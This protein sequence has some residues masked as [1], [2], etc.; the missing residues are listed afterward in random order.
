MK[1]K[2]QRL[3][4]SFNCPECLCR[5]VWTIGFV[6]F[7]TV[8]AVAQLTSGAYYRIT[9]VQYPELV[10]SEDIASQKI[11]CAQCPEASKKY[12]GQL[13]QVVSS[14][15]SYQ[16]RNALTQRY[17]RLDKS[18]WSVQFT[19][20]TSA[21]TATIS[22]VSGAT[23]TYKIKYNSYYFMHCDAAANVV[24]WTEDASASQWKFEK[25]TI[26]STDLANAQSAYTEITGMTTTQKSN[27]LTKMKKY[28]NG[29]ACGSL[30]GDYTSASALKTAMSNDGIPEAISLRA[31]EM[32]ETGADA[33]WRNR[34]R[35]HSYKAYSNPT[36]WR[37]KLG[38]SCLT[39]M[40]NPTGI[41][42]NDGEV[43]YVVVGGDIPTNAT[44]RLAS[45]KGNGILSSTDGVTLTKGLNA[46]Y[47]SGDSI[48]WY[49]QYLAETLTSNG[50]MRNL[51]AFNPIEIHIF[52]GEVTGF[53]ELD[54]TKSESEVNADYANLIGRAKSGLNFVVKGQYAMFNFPKETYDAIWGTTSYNGT[55]YGRKIYKSIKW[56]DNVER[57]QW[58]IMGLCDTVKA[59][60]RY[61]ESWEESITKHKEDYNIQQ[62]S[63]SYWPSRCNNLVMAIQV[64]DGVNPH[65]TSEYT[66]YPGVGS[67]ESSFNAER[68]NF[69]NWCV[70]HE[71]GHNNQLRINLPSCT[72][73]SNN[74]FSDVVVYQ[75]GYRGSRG[76]TVEMVNAD[77][78]KG[79]NFAL[80]DIGS[81]HRMWYQLYLYYHV[82]RKKP[83]FYPDLFQSLREDPIKLASGQTGKDSF[84]HFYKKACDAAGEDLTDFF[85][86][87]GFFVPLSNV[88]FEDYTNYTISM[89]QTEI[90]A[91][92]AEVKKKYPS[93]D[94]SA[95]ILLIEDRVQNLPR[96]DTHAS[97]GDMRPVHEGGQ[98]KAGIY[99]DHGQVFDYVTSGA[100][101]SCNYLVVGDTLKISGTGGL[102]FVVR[103]K[104]GNI[105]AVSNQNEI[106]L[107]SSLDVSEMTISVVTVTGE[108]AMD[109]LLES[110]NYDG[111]KELLSDLRDKAQTIV[112]NSDPTGT[113]VGFYRSAAVADLKSLVA[114]ATSVLTAE[115]TADYASILDRLTNEYAAVLAADDRIPFESDAVYTLCNLGASHYTAGNFY[116]KLDGENVCG[117]EY[118]DDGT[119]AQWVFE[120][121]SGDLSG[122]YYLR[123]VEAGKYIS[124]ANIGAQ[125]TATQT[126]TSG[127]ISYELSEDGT[128][129][130]VLTGDDNVEGYVGYRC[131]HLDYYKKVVSWSAD[132]TAS[133]W[134]ITKVDPNAVDPDTELRNQELERATRALLAEVVTESGLGEIPA[135]G[136]I[137]LQTTDASGRFYL[138]GGMNST[139]AVSGYENVGFGTGNIEDLVDGNTKATD[140]NGIY[141]VYFSTF[142][143]E[144][145]ENH[146]LAVDLGADTELPLFRVAYTSYGGYSPKVLRITGS[147]DGSSW[148]DLA[149]LG[150]TDADPL[151]SSGTTDYVS[152]VIAN[153]KK[154]RYL[155]IIVDETY[156]HFGYTH[157]AFAMTEFGLIDACVA[158]NDF[159]L[160]Q[161]YTG[162]DRRLVTSADCGVRMSENISSSQ[163]RAYYDMLYKAYTALLTAARLPDV[164][165]GVA[166]VSSQGSTA[167]E[168]WK[169][170]AIRHVSGGKNLRFSADGSA[171]VDG[172]DTVYGQEAAALSHLF[173]FEPVDFSENTYRLY[174]PYTSSYVASTGAVG[175]AVACTTDVA[176]AGL[177]RVKTFLNGYWYIQDVSNDQTIG[178]SESA[179]AVLGTTVPTAS[180][181]AASLQ[182]LEVGKGSQYTYVYH[183]G[184]AE[185]ETRHYG[186]FKWGTVP[187][188]PYTSVAFATF[189]GPDDAD[190]V[191]YGPRTINVEVEEQLPFDKSASYDAARWHSVE[192]HWTT[193]TAPQ[194]FAWTSRLDNA[195]YNVQMSQ[196]RADNYK[197]LMDERRQ[198][199]FVGNVIDGFRIYNRAAGAGMTLRKPQMGDNLVSLSDV[200]DCNRFLL[201]NSSVEIDTAACFR[202]P[203]DTYYIN[204][205]LNDGTDRI[206][207][208]WDDNDGGSSCRFQRMEDLFNARWNAALDSATFMIEQWANADERLTGYLSQ[209]ALDAQTAV[210]QEAGEIALAD[211]TLEKIEWLEAANEDCMHQVRLPQSGRQYMIISA[212]TKTNRQVSESAMTSASGSTAP[213][214]AALDRTEDSQRWHLLAG[215]DGY[216]LEPVTRPGEYVR[217]GST[218]S[219]QA[220]LSSDGT[221]FELD[222]VAPGQFAIREKTG[223][224]ALHENHWHDAGYT[225]GPLINWNENPIEDSPSSWRI[226]EIAHEV[227]IGNTGYATLYLGYAVDVPSG[228]NAMTGVLRDDQTGVRLQDVGTV[229]PGATAV[230]LRGAPGNYVFAYTDDDAAQQSVT[231]ENSLRGWLETTQVSSEDYCYYALRSSKS[232]GVGF[233]VPTV[234]QESG[235]IWAFTAD[236]HKAYLEVPRGMA[237]SNSFFGFLPGM[238]TGIDSVSADQSSGP[239]YDLGGRRVNKAVRGL[240]IK[241]GKKVWIK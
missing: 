86:V 24:S 234:Y 172:E 32:L 213:A 142:Q 95:A 155:R 233:Y 235:T 100:D 191:V 7:S 199:C 8:A 116:M 41:Y 121:A 196:M 28:F 209:S 10:M 96:W 84:L 76:E 150:G 38:S 195:D 152:D 236:A 52:G 204:S 136:K 231:A 159:E 138:S 1:K 239:V 232:N 124:Y 151:P 109:N 108:V 47:S 141:R 215:D 59:G 190:A 79:L 97:A 153:L 200:D 19:T 27:L 111:M 21:A 98:W 183:I 103:D 91:A 164:E 56:Y 210:V 89:T 188:H 160:S 73:S 92:I 106:A 147:A 166:E 6:L 211:V 226:E 126:T 15:S 29:E 137:A 120:P 187:V 123:N 78:Q 102:G 105:V 171:L 169:L 238:S 131:L 117:G 229:L 173:Q 33:D 129:K 135:E 44:L 194:R 2:K 26:N 62:T 158:R 69:D 237:Q 174:N 3:C 205:R 179:P 227:T 53:M 177:F 198:W 170:Y 43:L 140:A 130:F 207:R 18:G 240:Y 134:Y 241:E 94:N 197:A 182:L 23:N 180:T 114:E 48:Q 31:A 40:S 25:I 80:R 163:Q 55:T 45:V 61:E 39:P 104:S 201:F 223:H 181:N 42:S 65:S 66:A 157:S 64:A 193:L 51:S 148:E 50:T 87:W 67:I 119:S 101:P 168:P 112:N 74:F 35:V 202:L 57:W 143:S 175:S 20:S 165:Y 83:T 71:C 122:R 4:R 12:Y 178:R 189:T 133:H 144:T 37:D 36:L 127:A 9:N 176:S 218:Q 154:F 225:S 5:A 224:F 185:A 156:T 228:V 68:A 110:E 46:V 184:D 113:R 88:L 186:I 70:A 30:K 132:A 58:E 14:G 93:G 13:W 212:N 125:S 118:P 222:P 206:L 77:Y 214:W 139:G 107:P 85:R 203:G 16:L 162:I 82:A 128:G 75:Y 217:I 221:V 167:I 99:G 219:A 216:R 11:N 230:V 192:M 22:S 115:N 81:T 60:L 54:P 145:G 72:E 34:F 161:P 49:V 90:D 208:G 149:V 17:A 220:S 63:E 146:Y